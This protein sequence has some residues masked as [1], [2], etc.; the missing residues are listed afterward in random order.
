MQ[1][2]GQLDDIFA[3]MKWGR[4]DDAWPDAFLQ[5]CMF[6]LRRSKKVALPPEYKVLIPASELELDYFIRN[7]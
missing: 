6:Y 3:N 5:E 4:G 7:Q 1:A 2:K